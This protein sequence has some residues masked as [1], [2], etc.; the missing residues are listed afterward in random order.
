[1][2]AP[3]YVVDAFCDGPGSGNPAGVCPLAAEPD[4]GW[5]QLVARELNQAETAFLWP[6]GEGFRLRWFTP[7]LEVDLCGHATL[8]TAHVL[9]RAGLSGGFT[10]FQTLSGV[11][12]ASVDGAGL[13][14]LDFPTAPL[15]PVRADPELVAALGVEPL[16]VLHT[17]PFTDDLLFEVAGEATVR[18]LAPDLRAV[19][20][21]TR[22]GVVVTAPAARPGSGYDFVSR[23]FAPAVGVDEDPVTGSAHTALAP[24]WAARLERTELT[25]YQ[26]SRRG[27]HVR[28][29]L[30]GDRTHLSGHAVTTIDGDLLV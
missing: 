13:I 23:F 12:T 20:R 2:R 21:L 29:A 7:T 28:V 30:H 5:M 10:G 4:A 26:A 18:A 1:V 22:R 9:S 27:G 24:F 25:G 16:S 11:L 8:A 14:T 15:S 17:G 3:L 19:A 6:E